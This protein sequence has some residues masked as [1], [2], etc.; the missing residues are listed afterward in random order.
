MYDSASEGS[1]LVVDDEIHMREAMQSLLSG[2]G[3]VVRTAANGPLALEALV[4]ERPNLVV[5][6]LAMPGMNGVEVCRR[7]RGWSHVPILVLSA[8]SSEDL[9]V[10]ALE[11]GA[12]DYVTKP[13]SPREL[14]ARIGSAMRRE[15]ERQQE[16]PVVHAGSVVVD[17]AARRVLVAGAEV[18]LTPTEYELLRILATNPG[19]VLTH[20]FLLR[21]ALGP[22]YEDALESLRTF[23]KQLRRK[24]EPE[25]A[26]PRLIVSEPGVGYR[27]QAQAETS[28][29]PTV[30]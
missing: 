8:R 25:P 10:A 2:W 12:D 28:S 30:T 18:H 26:R 13:F 19:R 5:L 20:S 15:R 16:D 6:D 21:G 7:I 14:R 23:V 17:L 3:F 4:A 24:I 11:A 9:K 22:G 1:I 27:F 29:T